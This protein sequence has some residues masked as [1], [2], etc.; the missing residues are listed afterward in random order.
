VADAV[1]EAP[2]KPCRIGEGINERISKT[3]LKNHSF[4]LEKLVSLG[5]SIGM[6]S[7]THWY[8]GASVA[9]PQPGYRHTRRHIGKK[10]EYLARAYHPH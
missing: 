10:H 7:K 5:D 3:H 4:I 8:T 6:C 2:L 9:K 1:I